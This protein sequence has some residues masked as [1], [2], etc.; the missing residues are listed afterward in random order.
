M[1][2]DNRSMR[3]VFDKVGARWRRGDPGIVTTQFP[4][5]AARALLHDP[6]T[7]ASLLRSARQIGDAAAVALAG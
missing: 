3:A 1:L 5:A 4:V 6:V 2:N 7:E